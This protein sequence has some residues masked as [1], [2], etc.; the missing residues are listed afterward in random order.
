VLRKST[1]QAIDA[2][3]RKSEHLFAVSKDQTSDLSKLA[4]TAVV[5]LSNQAEQLGE[6]E[7]GAID[8]GIDAAEA[9]E[10]QADAAAGQR[11][12]AAWTAY[13][14]TL[15]PKVTDL[16]R[17]YVDLV[18][19]LAI[20]D[21]GLDEGICRIADELFGRSKVQNVDHSLT[22]PQS[23]TI[24]AREEA[25]KQTLARIIRL[26]FPEWW[27]IWALPL[28][29]HEL[30]YVVGTHT[31]INTLLNGIEA[32]N[33]QL[34]PYS[35]DYFADAF[36]TYTMGPAYAFAALFLRFDP[37]STKRGGHPPDTRR[38]DV[39]LAM[40]D[41]MSSQPGAMDPYRWIIHTLRE[42]WNGVLKRCG[43]PDESSPEDRQAISDLVTRL[44]EKLK[45]QTT[46]NYPAESWGSALDLK[47]KLLETTTG[48]I[49]VSGTTD[50]RSVLNAAWLARIAHQDQADTIERRARD[51]LDVICGM[52][53]PG[54]QDESFGKAAAYSGVKGQFS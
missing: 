22:I 18:R 44:G 51:A 27:T 15:L 17:D 23:I 16:F 29:A 14:D 52:K 31:E 5:N 32:V 13:R 39:V 36:A 10:Q 7:L 46:F 11:W 47:A 53:K 43:Q 9:Q 28:T 12:C 4:Q 20:R 1:N 24:P 2:L 54:K 21:A 25:L 45:R 50:L 3:K 49:T 37:F 33:K 41:W 30:G 35:T 40:L 26:S 19:G 38:A 48:P 34:A 42:E 6:N 8:R